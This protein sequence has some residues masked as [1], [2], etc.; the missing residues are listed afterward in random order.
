M[1]SDVGTNPELV[2][3][4]TAAAKRG[5]KLPVLAKMTPNITNMEI[6]E[7]AAIQAGA[8]GIAA[9][10]TVKGITNVDIDCFVPTP[11]INGKSAV[12]HA[13]KQ[14]YIVKGGE[15]LDIHNTG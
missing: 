13:P 5:T 9:I 2:E 1:G 12:I 15:A 7:I 10:N 4:Y 11:D 6:P 14:C 3:R 8:D